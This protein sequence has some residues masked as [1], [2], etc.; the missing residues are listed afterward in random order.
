MGPPPDND[1]E[2]GGGG[3]DQHVRE[4]FRRAEARSVSSREVF[5]GRQGTLWFRVSNVSFGTSMQKKIQKR[6]SKNKCRKKLKM[7]SYHFP[8]GIFF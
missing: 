3:G 7:R 2:G 1:D 5:E 6:K 8:P 4:I